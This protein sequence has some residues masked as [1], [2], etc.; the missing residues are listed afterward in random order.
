MTLFSNRIFSIAVAIS[1]FSIPVY[2]NTDAS[3][4][5]EET[6][7]QDESIDSAPIAEKDDAIVKASNVLIADEESEK[8]ARHDEANEIGEDTESEEPGIDEEREESTEIPAPT[9][10][11]DSEHVFNLEDDEA[12]E[13]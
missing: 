10:F 1:L 13:F 3:P 5:I 12:D 11:D 9:S 6:F 7:L 8:V 2:M 4:D